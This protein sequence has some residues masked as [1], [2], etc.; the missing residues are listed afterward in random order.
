MDTTVGLN[1]ELEKDGQTGKTQVKSYNYMPMLMVN[2]TP[3][4]E[5]RFELIDDK[6]LS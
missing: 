6:A 2:L 3:Q 4:V 1:I 5:S